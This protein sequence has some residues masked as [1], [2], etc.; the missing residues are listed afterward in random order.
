M[1]LTLLDIPVIFGL[2]IEVYFILLIIA[3]PTF[4]FWRWLLKKYIKVDRTRKIATWSATL[5][6]TPIIYVGLIILFMF[7]MSYKPSKDF[8]KSQWLT[9]KEG[10]FQMA[11]DLVKSKILIGKDTT[12]IKQI[13]GDPTWG[14]D[15]T[16]EWTYDMG[17]GGGMFSSLFHNLNLTFDKKGKVISVEHVKIRD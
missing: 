2:S 17:F 11:G 6:G 8:D 14:G 3:I 16:Q 5:I 1:T 10:R 7:G 15:T 12:Q 13:L 9:D 4:F